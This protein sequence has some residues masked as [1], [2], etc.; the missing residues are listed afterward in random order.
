MIIFYKKKKKHINNIILGKKKKK[1]VAGLPGL[2]VEP[3][4]QLCKWFREKLGS[5]KTLG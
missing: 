2:Q 1:K 3:S 5:I 4:N